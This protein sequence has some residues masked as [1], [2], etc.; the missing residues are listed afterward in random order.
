MKPT[1][2]C[3]PAYS[4]SAPI[5]MNNSNGYNMERNAQEALKLLPLLLL[6][7]LQI[8]TRFRMSCLVFI[9]IRII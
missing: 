2:S 7:P 5:K 8:F 9:T 4:H 3:S 1:L 6:L